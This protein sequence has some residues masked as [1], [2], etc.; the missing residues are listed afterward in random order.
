[1]NP[2]R[3]LKSK[4]VFGTESFKE[5]QKGLSNG[6]KREDFE[7]MIARAIA[8]L[9]ENIRRKI[10]NLAFVVEE[11]SSP[12]SLLGL[13]QGIPKNTWGRGFV[14]RLPDKITI[15]KKPIK[16]NAF[17][18]KEIYPVKSC[19]AGAT[20]SQ[21]NRVENLVK[22]VVYHEITHYLGFDEKEV[23][24]WESRRQKGGL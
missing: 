18:E 8:S 2:V 17:S 20:K 19:E 15:F 1:M 3:K 6:V 11:D 5:L 16:K 7:K 9:P 13:Y 21:F 24:K 4:S 23:R 14:S 22:K 10:E 12:K